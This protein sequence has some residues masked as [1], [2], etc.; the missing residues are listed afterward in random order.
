MKNTIKCL[1]ITALALL[2]SLLMTTCDD[3]GNGENYKKSSG[4]NGENGSGSKPSTP[5]AGFYTR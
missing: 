5:T 2:L 3:S 1:R 4:D